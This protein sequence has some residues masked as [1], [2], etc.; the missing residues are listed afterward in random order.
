M[1]KTPNPNSTGSSGNADA[2]KPAGEEATVK[3]PSK[4]S[5]KKNDKKCEHLVSINEYYSIIFTILKGYH[6][7][8][9][10][11]KEMGKRIST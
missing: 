8:S 6:S 5:K 1:S 4:D 3:V 9:Y 7:L 10:C 11:K 2:G